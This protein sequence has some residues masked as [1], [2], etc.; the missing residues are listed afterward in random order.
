MGGFIPAIVTPFL[1]AG[2][3]MEDAFAS[4]ID[5]LIGLGARGIGARGIGVAEDN[6]AIPPYPLCRTPGLLAILRP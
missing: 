6:G 5:W 1:P 2:E 4:M 3:I